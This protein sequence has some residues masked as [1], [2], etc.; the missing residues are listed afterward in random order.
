MD[1]NQVIE[2]ILRKKIIAIVRGYSTEEVVK[3]AAALH[4]GGVDLLEITFPTE[5]EEGILEVTEKLRALNAALGS[6]M[7]FGTGTVTTMEMVRAAK[8][9]GSA[10]IIS[11]DTN[12]EVIQETCRLGLVSIPGALTPTEIKHAHD[13]GADFV[14]VFPSFVV[15]PAY[16][17]A[18]L[19]PFNGI[20]LLAVG[21]VG[22]QDAADYLKAGA[23]GVGVAGCL[24]R[25][26]WILARQ[27]EKITEAAKQ[28]V[29]LVGAVRN[30]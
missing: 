29:S 24:F 3:L 18:V 11:P 21:S 27:W 10:F 17:K 30:G 15:G 14:K 23:C 8:E 26:E 25:K 20:R 16:F 22:E 6:E 4:K 13:C 1:K 19:A 2:T 5:G 12:E 7:L 28:F 9:A